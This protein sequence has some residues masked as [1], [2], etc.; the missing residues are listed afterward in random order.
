MLEVEVRRRRGAFELDAAFRAPTPGL[1]ALFGR[2]GCGKTTLVDLIAGLLAPDAGRISLDGTVLVDRAAGV[3][4]PVERRRIGYVFQDARLFPHFDV[5]GNLRYGAK[6]ARGVAVRIGFDDVV[7]LLGLGA[8]L[9]RRPASLSGGERQRVALG[10][11]LLAQPRLLLLDEPLASLDAARRDEVLPY[12]ERLRDA[13]AIPMVYV[14][15]QLDEVQR[16]A[17]HVVLLED[18][19]VLA[20]GGLSEVSLD[21]RMRAIAGPDAIGAV[22]DCEV[23]GRDPESGLATVRLGEGALRIRA[24]QAPA[25]RVRL[26]L[27]ARD[28]IVALQEPQGLSVRNAL[29]AAVTAVEPDDDHTD[30]VRLDAGGAALVARITRAAT[31]ELGLRPGLQVW[32]LVK[33]VSLQGIPRSSPEGGP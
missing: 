1:V 6:R 3:S 18:G 7:A 5:A 30:L 10:R 25:D 17:T 12:L 21:A 14:S 31:R 9:A 2:S 26:R 33:S 16:L 22:L 15:H 32:V 28:L 29:R 23:I 27:P 8:L 13:L 20:A 19:R 24:D 11:A 4:V